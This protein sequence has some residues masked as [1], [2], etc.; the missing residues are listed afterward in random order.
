MKRRRSGN[1][2]VKL[3]KG[4]VEVGWFNQRREGVHCAGEAYGMGV[5]PGRF[6]DL[7]LE[8]TK[9]AQG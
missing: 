3:C 8:C 5:D 6:L 4:R 1:D 2:L 9:D 7:D